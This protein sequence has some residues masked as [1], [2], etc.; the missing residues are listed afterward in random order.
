VPRQRIVASTGG[1]ETTYRSHYFNQTV[2]IGAS[3]QFFSV[4]PV[5]PALHF[6]NSDPGST[7]AR[8]Y[9]EYVCPKHGIKYTPAVGTTTA[10]SVWMAYVDN[11]EIIYNFYS[12]TYTGSN[13]LQIAQSTRHSKS[14]PVWMEME[15]SAPVPPRRKMFSIDSTAPA[16]SSEADR[17][18]Q[19]LYIVVT[20]NVPLNTTAGYLSDGYTAKVRG[21]QLS[22]VTGI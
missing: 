21:L 20:T 16:N 8:Q 14:G 7:V 4:I 12:G 6:T 3:L 15:F 11:P 2:A 1:E 19:G 10:G 22:A 5:A 17:T 13:Y 9:Q 18:I